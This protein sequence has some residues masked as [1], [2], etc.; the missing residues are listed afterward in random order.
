MISFEKKTISFLIVSLNIK[1]DH[2][3]VR[4]TKTSLLVE[5]L[6]KPHFIFLYLI[7]GR[8]LKHFSVIDLESVLNFVLLLAI[9]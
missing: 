8:K 4:D 5:I 6:K 7:D 9:N 2:I 3:P 1:Y